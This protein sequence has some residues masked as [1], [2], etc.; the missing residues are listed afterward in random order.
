MP[1][2][3][4]YYGPPLPTVLNPLNPAHYWLVFKW[5]FFQPSRLRHY[6]YQIDPGLYCAR[7]RRAIYSI[8]YLPGYR[9]LG[10][11]VM[12]GISL[13]IVG[14]EFGT[15]AT[16]ATPIYLPNLLLWWAAFLAIIVLFSSVFG[17]AGGVA[18]VVAPLMVS[19]SCMPPIDMRARACVVQ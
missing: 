14:V 6:L 10:I 11:I 18:M 13:A 15:S 3:P 16:R 7:G 12:V 19:V 8:F 17:A 9:N 4:T 1:T 5:V 2:F